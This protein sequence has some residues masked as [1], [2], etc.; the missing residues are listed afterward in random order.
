MNIGGA[1]YVVTRRG[2]SLKRLTDDGMNKTSAKQQSAFGF[3]ANSA[4]T[5]YVAAGIY[6]MNHDRILR[7]CGS[8]LLLLSIR[9]RAQAAVLRAR[10]ARLKKKPNAVH[11]RTEYCS[12][13]N[14]FGKFFNLPSPSI[15]RASCKPSHAPL[16]LTS[17][18]I[19]LTVTRLC[20]PCV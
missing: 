17:H 2:N 18:L 3:S 9:S 19:N 16:R 11:V 15:H 14:R 5:T 7:F 8:Y 10:N 12:F 1:N 20:S 6:C 4:S 13:F